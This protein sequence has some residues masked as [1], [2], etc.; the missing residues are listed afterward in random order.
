VS[1]HKAKTKEPTDD[2]RELSKHVECRA[3]STTNVMIVL[4]GEQC[5]FFQHHKSLPVNKR[6]VGVYSI[7]ILGFSLSFIQSSENP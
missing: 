4:D 7:T 1:K 2:E 3:K 5:I 6:D